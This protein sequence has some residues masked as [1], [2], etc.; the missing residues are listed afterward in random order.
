MTESPIL[1]ESEVTAPAAP[2]SKSSLSGKKKKPPSGGAKGAGG[3]VKNAKKL[4]QDDQVMATNNSS[5]V[6]KRSVEKLYYPNE[7]HYFRFFVKRF[8]RRSPLINRGYHL[9]LHVIDVLVRDFLQRPRIP[10]KSKKKRVVVNL[11]CGSDVLPWQCLERYPTDCQAGLVKFLDVDF[12][13]LIERKRQTV[14]STPELLGAFTGVEERPQQSPLGPSSGAVFESDQYAQIG[15]DLRELKT[16]QGA[17]TKTLGDVDECSFLFVAEVS[18]TYMETEGADNVIQWASTL[19]DAE[20]VLLEQILPSGEH[21]PFASTM[22]SHF[23]KLNTPPKSVQVY[24]TVEAQHDRFS[25]RGWKAVDVWTLWQ[26]WADDRFLSASDRRKLE[27]IEPFDEWE[28]FALFAS[29]YC[30]VH[31][32]TSAGTVPLSTVPRSEFIPVPSQAVRLQFDECHGQRGQRRFGAAMYVSPKEQASPVMVNVMGLGTK[33]RLQSCDVYSEGGESG[34]GAWFTMREGGPSTRMCHSLTC[35]GE[36]Q[37]LL[38]GGRGAPMIPYKDCWLF[39][40]SMTRWKRT[41]DLPTSLH[42]HSVTRL[43]ES[44]QV[45]LAGGRGYEGIFGDYLVYHPEAGWTACEVV[46]ICRPAYVYGAVLC[47][48]SSPPTKK[49]GGVFAGGLLEDGTIADQILSW[50]LDISDVAKPTIKFVPLRVTVAGVLMTAGMA[51]ICRRLLTRFGACCVPIQHYGGCILLGG[52]IKDHLLDRQD[53]ILVCTLSAD[54]VEI[55]RR[56]VR[57]DILEGE[58]NISLPP[59]PLLV[60]NSTVPLPDGRVV[61]AGGGATCFSMGTFWNRGVYTLKPTVA[62]ENQNTSSELPHWVHDRTVD[63]IPGPENL[64]V[65]QPQSK[66]GGQGSNPRIEPIARIQ[67]ESQEAFAK[68]IREGKPAVLEGLDLGP[69]VLNWGLE[70]LVDKVGKDRKVVVHEAVTQAMDFNAKNFRYLTTDF[71]DFVNR[72]RQGD[73][74]Y[75]RALSNDMPTEKPA[76]LS[77]DFLAL[78]ADF[79]IPPQLSLVKENIFS[80]VLRVSGPVNMWLHYDV[81]ANVYCQIGGSKRLVLFPPTDVDRLGFA[82]GAS[83]SSIDVFS[84]LATE[85]SAELE[86]THPYEAVLSPGDVLFLPPLWLHTATPTSDSSIAVNVFFRDLDSGYAPGRDVYGNRDLAAYEKGRQDVAR[87]TNSFGKLPEDARRFYL[88]RLADELRRK[89]LG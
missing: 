87:M 34:A 10:G 65:A 42:R 20:F 33:S 23:N 45:L 36:G 88:L 8:Q 18:I 55:T 61:L 51:S 44:D 43:G 83:S 75:L 82:P 5:I 39:D 58:A 2:P 49:F 32:R 13:D 19:G 1:A 7:A 47:C 25:F 70:R 16:L 78:A 29:H 69:C 80:S 71:E 67:L 4:A 79:V 24:P 30:V 84:S 12:P 11:G 22:L 89:A 27:D 66:A 21:H 28:E 77:E 9:R 26:A 57:A 64:S 85:D 17:L 50:E 15:C 53:E 46:G 54:G 76:L 31:A 40:T 6:S 3:L 63:I 62:D 48:L 14:L 52:V 68:L 81:M 37:F 74:L 60:G 35:V 86:H 72:V 38:S 41:H 73:W 56:L 59:R